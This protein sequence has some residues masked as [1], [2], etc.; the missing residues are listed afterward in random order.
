[1][2]PL[3]L[4]TTFQFLFQVLTFMI[5]VVSSVFCGH[6]GRVE[7]ASVTLSV[8]VST[9]VAVRGWSLPGFSPG[10]PRR[11]SVRADSCIHSYDLRPFLIG[12]QHM[13]MDRV[14]QEG[15]L[16]QLHIR[17]AAGLP[18][19]L[20]PCLTSLVFSPIYGS[21]LSMSVGFQL[22][23]AFPQPVTP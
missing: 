9:A 21:S 17:A 8:T 10:L 3:T 12:P 18:P 22:D 1:M 6:L 23:S 5:Y 7:L 15:S 16:V 20:G 19:Q 14:G 11:H 4:A 13:Q 2:A